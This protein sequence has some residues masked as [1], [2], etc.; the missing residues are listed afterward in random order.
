MYAENS[1]AM[2]ACPFLGFFRK[3][4]CHTFIANDFR[5]AN[6]IQMVFPG[7][8]LMKVLDL[9]TGKLPAIITIRERDVFVFFAELDP[10]GCTVTRHMHTYC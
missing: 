4:C 3:K 10:A 9:H 1:A 5:V 6:Q 8:S 7:I 2:S